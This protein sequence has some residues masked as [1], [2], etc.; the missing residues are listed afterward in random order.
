MNCINAGTM[1]VKL[2]GCMAIWT[3]ELFVESLCNQTIEIMTKLFTLFIAMLLSVACYGQEK[4]TIKI[5]RAHV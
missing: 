1:L 5:G 4:L 2:I 3:E